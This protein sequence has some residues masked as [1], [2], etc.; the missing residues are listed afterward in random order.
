MSWNQVGLRYTFG[1]R[2]C[3]DSVEVG[4]GDD[5]GELSAKA[6]VAGWHGEVT[7]AEGSEAAVAALRD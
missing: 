6:M 7:G 1:C 2:A 4:G 3:G 5:A